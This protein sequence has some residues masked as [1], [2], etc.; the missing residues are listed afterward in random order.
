MNIQSKT[1]VARKKA[2]KGDVNVSGSN[3]VNQVKFTADEKAQYDRNGFLPVRNIFTPEAVEGIRNVAERLIQ[4]DKMNTDGTLSRVAFRLHED[5]TMQEIIRSQEFADVFRDLMERRMIFTE[6]QAFELSKG[7][8]GLPWHFGYISFGYI[9]PE[10]MACTLWVPL[11]PVNAKK[12]GGGMAY[13]PESIYS[14]R[15]DYDLGSMLADHMN[16]GDDI[17]ELLGGF[18]QAHEAME[19]IFEENAV[20]DDFNVGDAFL[21]N[22][23]VWHR[24]SRFQQKNA[25]RRIGVAF[26]F[27]DLNSHLDKER[28]KAEFEFGGGISTGIKKYVY[29]AQEDRFSRFT[30][31]EHGGAI[32]FSKDVKTVV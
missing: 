16:K 22:K 17:E 23:N 8:T 7:G 29:A 4:Q 24:S 5:P 25:T 27:I 32:R 11:S 1:P 21:F 3:L 20:E 9:R 31:V 26:R 19:P 30:D 6:A 2:K 28:W 15:R 18:K 10:D 14:A 12:T 13:V